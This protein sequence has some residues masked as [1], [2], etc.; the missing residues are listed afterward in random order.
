MPLDNMGITGITLVLG[1][2]LAWALLP[3]MPLYWDLTLH[4]TSLN[5]LLTFCGSHFGKLSV[6]IMKLFSVLAV[7]HLHLF[8]CTNICSKFVFVFQTH[9]SPKA[10]IWNEKSEGEIGSESPRRRDSYGGGETKPA[11]RW[12]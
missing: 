3:V 10:R 2:C 1:Y 6:V 7:I 5:T 4:L 8:F 9:V 12:R 11:I